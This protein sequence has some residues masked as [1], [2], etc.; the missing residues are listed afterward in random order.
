MARRA[1]LIANGRFDADPNITRLSSP[2]TDIEGVR[3]LLA[4]PEVGGYEVSTCVD[5]TASSVRFAV[6][7]FF[8]KASV[9]DTHLVLISG[10]GI[11]DSKG[12]LHFATADTQLRAIN[13]TS[14]ESR[15]VIERMDES[16]A[17]QQILLLD[18]CYSGAFMN[19]VVSKGAPPPLTRDEFGD[20]LAS[21]RAVMTATSSIQEAGEAEQ[22]GRMQSMFTRL[23]IEGIETGRA[24]PR[25]TGTIGLNDLFDFIRNEFRDNDWGQKPELHTYKLNGAM[26]V[27]YNPV[28]RIIELPTKLQASINHKEKSRRIA[29]IDD[30]QFL[31]STN[32]PMKQRALEALDKLASDDSSIIKRLAREA[33]AVARP[34]PD[35]I[36]LGIISSPI[37]TPDVLGIGGGGDMA[38]ETP[39]FPDVKKRLKNLTITMALLGV[40]ASISVSAWDKW[41][42]QKAQD[43]NFISEAKRTRAVAAMHGNWAASPSACRH[44][45]TVISFSVKDGAVQLI[46]AEEGAVMSPDAAGWF[47]FDNGRYRPR[48]GKL[49]VATLRGT[50]NPTEFSKCP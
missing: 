44:T 31:I 7:D 41:Q 2:C 8:D 29:A 14:L 33:L 25:Q 50:E 34:S 16:R 15:Y 23:L 24:D 10:H 49:D 30:L 9:S 4:R 12:K 13:A 47:R 19:G 38:D 43:A 28:P 45:N 20:S 32:A 35:K 37:I 17:S 48:A 27:A 22:A 21:G 6:Q 3:A 46:G 26:T 11:K 39:A 40:A 1:L 42:S 5:E 36:P 18:T